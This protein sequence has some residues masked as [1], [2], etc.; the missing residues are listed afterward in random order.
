MPRVQ[1]RGL[2][3]EQGEAL[4]EAVRQSFGPDRA[5][6]RGRQLD[7]Q[8]Q[9]VEPAAD[10]RRRGQTALVELESRT[11]LGGSVGE[12][13]HGGGGS[14]LVADRSSRWHAERCE[15]VDELAGQTQG[16]TTGRQH[17][18]SRQ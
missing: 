14:S 17:G 15:D 5:H 18:E 10:F 3:G 8:R 12:Q 4:I 16:R 9:A 11:C 2:A 1:A 6:P 7:R 13:P